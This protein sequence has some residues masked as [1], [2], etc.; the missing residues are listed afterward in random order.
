[1][2]RKY[3]EY[4]VKHGQGIATNKKY[5]DFHELNTY[6]TKLNDDFKVTNVKIKKQVHKLPIFEF[7]FIN[8]PNDTLPN[9]NT[10]N[11]NTSNDN[12]SND[13]TSS[14]NTSSDNTTSAIY[15]QYE[16]LYNRG[17]MFI[18]FGQSSFPQKI[19]NQNQ[20]QNQNQKKKN[21]NKNHNNN[22]S[23]YE[24]WNEIANEKNNSPEL[25]LPVI[26]SVYNLITE[27]K[28]INITD[29]ISE[30]LFKLSKIYHTFVKEK[31]TFKDILIKKYKESLYITEYA[32]I[33]EIK[34]DI[35]KLEDEIKK[36][37]TTDKA[38]IQK[39]INAKKKEKAK[40]EKSINKI[41]DCNELFGFLEKL[42][43]IDSFFETLISK[44]QLKCFEEIGLNKN[45][46]LESIK[47]DVYSQIKG[48]KSEK[49]AKKILEDNG[50]TIIH[51]NWNDPDNGREF[52]YVVKHENNEYGIVEVKSTTI[53]PDQKD[54]QLDIIQKGLQY[55]KNNKDQDAKY[56]VLDIYSKQ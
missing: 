35:K 19:I 44:D 46:V 48:K 1:M 11:D 36:K 51:S 47:S 7:E 27:N 49:N 9:D 14:D 34:K 15:K 42:I 32:K 29:F 10:S 50:Y 21:Q 18:L 5:N 52:D 28:N 26:L 13:N 41:L 16:N 12:T 17:L 38:M 33:E 2:K 37:T 6:L 3:I 24:I 53:D 22:L 25:N 54:K 40:Y 30:D 8:T 20:N 55:K 39:Q 4:K 31:Q 23:P 43:S 45:I 56:Q